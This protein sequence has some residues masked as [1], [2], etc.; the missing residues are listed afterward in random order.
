MFSFIRDSVDGK[1]IQRSDVTTRTEGPAPE[2][3]DAELN[4]R[5]AALQT[6]ADKPDDAVT[7]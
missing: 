3:S 4:A 7:H 1:P 6:D 2:L 5:L